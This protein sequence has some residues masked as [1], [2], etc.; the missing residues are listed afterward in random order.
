VN[1]VWMLDGAFAVLERAVPQNIQ[2]LI[3]PQ[4]ERLSADEHRLLEA[5][6]VVGVEFSAATVATAS[7]IDTGKVKQWCESLG[8]RY[9]FLH[10][11]SPSPTVERRQTA[12]Y[13]FHHS[14]VFTG[15]LYPTH[16]STAAPT[17]SSDW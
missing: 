11:C 3:E 16:T 7:A 15:S 9:L 17:A 12:R 5:A 8:R 14:L 2:Q 13:R 1:E 4:V 10:P 6:S